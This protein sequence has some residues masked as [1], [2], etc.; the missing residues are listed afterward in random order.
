MSEKKYFFS[1]RVLKLIPGDQ[2]TYTSVDQIDREDNEEAIVFPEEYLHSLMPTGL[3]PHR[4]TLKVGSIVMLLRNLNIKQGLCNG[5]RLVVRRM[6]DHVLDCEL[7]TGHNAGTR[8]LIPQI[9]L[10]PAAD[11]TNIPFTRRQFP[12]RLAFAMTI[13]K[14]QGQTFDNV[15]VYLKDCPVFAHGQLYVA[16]SRVTSSFNLKVQLSPHC[17][18]TRNI[19]YHEI[20]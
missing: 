7:L 18:R 11:G 20:L 4:L 6:L 9:K 16:F 19:V 15:G 13:N 3:P 5:V 10:K 14:A 8:V 12:V 2:K 1:L 17:N